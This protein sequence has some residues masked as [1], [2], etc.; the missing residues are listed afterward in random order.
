MLLMPTETRVPQSVTLLA[1]AYALLGGLI[2][3]AG[4]VLGVSRLADW[5]GSGIVMKANT[6]LAA[7]A[8]GA[9]LLVVA[10]YPSAR[11]LIRP[12]ALFVAGL[13][14]LTLFQHITGISLGIDTLLFDESAGAL[15]TAAPGRMGPPAATSFLLI[16]TALIL[17]TRGQ[18]ARGLAVALALVTFG[19]GMLSVTG[20]AYGAEAMYTLPRLTGIAVQ[21]ATMIA[22]LAVGLIAAVPEHEPLVTLR[23]D[24][25]AGLLARRLLPFVLLVPLLIGW[26]RLQGQRMGLYDTA[27]GAAMR[28]VLE[29]VLLAALTFWSLRAI[30]SRETE[31]DRL[32]DELRASER[33]LTGTLESISDGLMTLDRHWRFA[34]V[35]AEAERLLGR[36]R[37]S[38]LGQVVWELFPEMVG[39]PIERGFR[40]AA[41]ER[42]TLEL[43]ST[44][45][46]TGHHFS[47]RIYPASDGG[48]AI[49]FHDITRRKQVE[50]AL[51]EAD[52]RKD[53]FLATLA[54]ELR[55]PLAP[56]R[57]A[58]R[59]LL[60]N[61]SP[62]PQ[63]RWGA[64]VIHRQVDHM[65]RLLDDLL[66][67]SRIS[68]NRL[69][70]RK[71]WVDLAT[72]IASALETSRPVIDAHRHELTVDGPRETTYV[73]ADPVRLAQVFSNLV[74]NAAKYMEGS[75]H[76]R[77]TTERQGNEAVI[78]IGDEG[79]G[80]APDVLPHIFEIFWQASP[81]LERS[82]G[83]LGIGLS[84]A[85][86]IVE[87]HGGR[88]EARS[89]GL[90]QG[91]EFI[92]R[93]PLVGDAAQ[94]LSVRPGELLVAG[95]SRRVMIV[96][97]VR[98][99]ADT[100][101]VL[102]RTLGHEVHSVYDA[103]QA[104]E[105][106]DRVRP[107]AVL[108]DIG[109]P[110]LDGFEVCRQLR[111][112]PWGKTL[113]IVAVTGW[114]HESDRARTEDAGFDHHLI[115]PADLRSLTTLLNAGSRSASRRTPICS[116][117]PSIDSTTGSAATTPPRS[118]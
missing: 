116:N 77:I 75:G 4:W 59:L 86:G 47:N 85:R 51:R 62:D 101:A 100:L 65:S 117:Q 28:T 30:R 16:G 79:M 31:R 12:L 8:A 84:L 5:N 99:N 46:V 107:D 3:F 40:R 11:G 1:G 83:G 89:S 111:Q 20:H 33:R 39:T 55:N 118:A 114:G 98:D 34:Y 15:A 87:L 106:A 37:A 21:T 29:I 48:V 76:I 78:S 71:E 93:L 44:N 105:V 82:H 17:L 52:R 27:F 61:G 104:I 110:R 73:D 113:L 18:R 19:I 80:M 36:Q 41:V 54:H 109:M 23:A 14:G 74:N 2:S 112:Q 25:S 68:R 63:L 66:D 13:G 49:Y 22:A 72:V 6:A 50:N 32:D 102:L 69:E 90:G 70:L 35:N 43:D 103:E 96:D 56:I 91:S 64:E 81:A 67:V 42:V 92:V 24:S 97:D 94:A 7:S 108:L 26:L 88:I 60:L 10:G 95:R 53:E 58:A 38:L 9:A 115:K 45:P 57:N